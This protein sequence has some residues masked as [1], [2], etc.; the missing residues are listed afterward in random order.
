MEKHG[1]LKSR[2]KPN[3]GANS[4]KEYRLTNE[5]E[6]VLALI[7]EQVKELHREVVE[8]KPDRHGRRIV[9]SRRP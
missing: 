9:M 3:V 1:W 8:G 2:Q 5:G 6:K 4:R 7:R